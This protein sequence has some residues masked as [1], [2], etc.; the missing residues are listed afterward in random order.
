MA[1]K[2]ISFVAVGQ[3][4]AKHDEHYEQHG[5]TVFVPQGA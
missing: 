2:Q 5:W 4:Q 1:K 3:V